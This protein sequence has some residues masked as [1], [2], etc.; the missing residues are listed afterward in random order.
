MTSLL[1]AELGPCEVV[2][3][4][5][6]MYCF[7]PCVVVAVVVSGSRRS[8]KLIYPLPCPGCWEGRGVV[9]ELLSVMSSGL[10]SGGGEEV[11]SEM[12]SRND[13]LRDHDGEAVSGKPSWS[14]YDFCRVDDRCLGRVV[15]VLAIV[16]ASLNRCS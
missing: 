5:A 16:S 8:R 2:N 11:G 3:L 1:G 4:M 6:R 10:G 13:S 7:Y 14:D 12:G 15:V 9:E